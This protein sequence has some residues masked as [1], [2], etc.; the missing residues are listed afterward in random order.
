M[1]IDV[2]EN[3]L[4]CFLFWTCKYTKYFILHKDW[5]PGFSSL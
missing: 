4:W 1:F 3:K 2:G 5:N